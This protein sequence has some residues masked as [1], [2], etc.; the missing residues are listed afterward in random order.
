M[1]LAVYPNTAGLSAT[2]VALRWH[3]LLTVFGFIPGLNTLVG[4]VPLH[5]NDIWL[6]AVLAAIAGYFGLFRPP[7]RIGRAGLRRAIPDESFGGRGRGPVAPSRRARPRSRGSG[8]EPARGSR[9]ESRRMKTF[10][11]R[12]ATVLALGFIVCGAV[13]AQG[14]VA[15]DRASGSRL[16]PLTRVDMADATGARIYDELASPSGE[17]PRGALGTLLH[18]PATAAAFGRIDRYL[19]KESAVGGRLAGL[20]ALVAARELNLAYRVE[21]S[22]GR[23]ACG[24]APGRGG[25]HRSA[26]ATALPT[27]CRATTS[28]LVDF[29]RQL[30]RNRY[31]RSET[32]AA[33]AERLE[34]AGRVRRDHAARPI[35][36]WPASSQR[37]V[38]QQAAGRLGCR[39]LAAHRRCR[40]ADRPARRVRAGSR[41]GRRCRATCTK[42]RTIASRCC[43]RGALDTPTR[44]LLRSSRGRRPG[45]D[46]AR[47]VGM[48]F[49]SPALVEPV[50][51]INTALRANGVLGTRLAEIV[52]AA[53][54]REM[55]SQY[56]WVVHGAAAA[57]AGAGQAVL[58]AIRDDAPLAGLDERDAVAIAFTREAVSRGD[59]TAA[60]RSP[61]PCS[62]SARRAR[63]RWLP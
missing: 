23:G 7:S 9:L 55:N 32:F 60:R 26:A 47:P 35:P 57:T 30:Y 29:G 39:A 13:S 40:D 24:G 50:Q 3:A 62:Y 58:E 38:G 48:T 41:S 31:V 12:T 61:R 53:T 34:S 28:L 37:A 6:H 51:D 36:R 5:G 17:A 22:R 63:S 11:I 16:P 33:L 49:L 52:V 19:L 54:G 14:G 21:R 25:R 1:G 44:E 46:A 8:L 56:Q 43:E 42:T 4:L 45:H 10:G 20:L 27:R 15:I 18:S 59:G 2:R